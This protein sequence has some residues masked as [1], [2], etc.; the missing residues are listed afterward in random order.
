MMSGERSVVFAEVKNW[1]VDTWGNSSMRRELLEQL[2][3]HDQGVK[4]LMGVRRA[5]PPVKLLMVR[6]SGYEMFD[7]RKRNEFKGAFEALGWT[8]ELIPDDRIA[9][10]SDVLDGLK[11]GV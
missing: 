7:E 3:W 5:D 9:D 8:L 2:G 10:F 11:K 1:S 4:Q 6:Q